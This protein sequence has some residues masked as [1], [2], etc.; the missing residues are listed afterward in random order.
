MKNNFRKNSQKQYPRRRREC[1]GQE[2]GAGLCCHCHT[3]PVAAGLRQLQHLCQMFCQSTAGAGAQGSSRGTSHHGQNGQRSMEEPPDPEGSQRREAEFGAV[4]GLGTQLGREHCPHCESTN[5][6]GVTSCPEPG[7]GRGQPRGAVPIHCA[8]PGV[9]C[10]STV[11]TQRCCAH[12]GVLC[13]VS[14]AI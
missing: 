12:P 13:P 2:C 3:T 11:P 7:A 8:H 1:A 6:S 10:P 9:L 4:L 5:S 14:A